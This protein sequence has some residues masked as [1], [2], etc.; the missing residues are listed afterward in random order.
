MEAAAIAAGPTRNLTAIAKVAMEFPQAMILGCKAMNKP[1]KTEHFTHHSK[2][3][4]VYSLERFKNP[5]PR[6]NIAMPS[7]ASESIE[8]DC[9]TMAGISTC[10]LTKTTRKT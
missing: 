4:F 2:L 9:A 5:V 7:P 3:T 6:L 8:M 1:N 10:H